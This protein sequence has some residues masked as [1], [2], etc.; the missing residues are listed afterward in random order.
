MRLLAARLLGALAV[1]S[2]GAGRSVLASA[3]ACPLACALSLRARALGSE[4]AALASSRAAA[5]RLL[6]SAAASAVQVRSGHTDDS[7]HGGADEVGLEILVGLKNHTTSK[8][9]TSNTERSARA[10]ARVRPCMAPVARYEMRDDVTDT[11]RCHRILLSTVASRATSGCGPI[12]VRMLLVSIASHDDTR[13]TAEGR[14]R[15]FESQAFECIAGGGC[16]RCTGWQVPLCHSLLFRRDRQLRA[17][18]GR[19]GTVVARQGDRW[20][21]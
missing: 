8:Q 1:G 13:R 3:S 17:V 21:R 15:R 16:R 20:S 14:R 18:R 4:L 2:A 12:P 11:D 9:F 5:A 10:D 19:A 7:H 6:G